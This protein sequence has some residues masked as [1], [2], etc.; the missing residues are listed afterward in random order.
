MQTE[1]VDKT[2]VCDRIFVLKLSSGGYEWRCLICKL[3]SVNFQLLCAVQIYM[4]ILT[5][6]T[7]RVP[8]KAGDQLTATICKMQKFE[9][10]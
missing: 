10:K 8:S 7:E 3:I 6:G 5:S 4:A 2:L 1:S 9:E